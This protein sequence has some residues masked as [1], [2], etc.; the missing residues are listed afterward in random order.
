MHTPTTGG[1][2][3]VRLEA[4]FSGREHFGICL[5]VLEMS[6]LQCLCTA[7]V[8]SGW[9]LGFP[10]DARQIS[11]SLPC[12]GWSVPQNRQWAKKLEAISM[13]EVL[14]KSI[15]KALRS[16]AKHIPK[17]SLPEKHACGLAFFLPSHSGS[18]QK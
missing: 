9:L 6:T 18:R 5:F 2:E 15:A 13:A 7:G 4:C 3:K 11:Q 1:L 8:C 16:I 17:R 14:S 10:M 12:L